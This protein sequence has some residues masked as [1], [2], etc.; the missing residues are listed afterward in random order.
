MRQPD[1]R[2]CRFCSAQG[3]LLP[4][5]A[6]RWRLR[7]T[8]LDLS[9]GVLMGVLNVTPDSFSD[10]GLHLDPEEAVEHGLAMVHQGA[11]IIDVGGESTRPGSEPVHER[12]ELDRVLPVVE[13]L[14]GEGVTVSIDTSKPV[15][16]ESAF[17]RGAEILND[18][19]AC[20]QPGMAELVAEV[21]CG[22]VLMHMMGTP[23]AMHLD[24][25]YD[26][27]IAEVEEFLVQRMELVTAAGVD[28]S[29]IVIDPGIGFGKTA[30]HNLSLINALE[31][32][33]RHAP[34]VL[35]A[36][37]KKFLG[38]ITGASSP[39]DRDLASAVIT[40]VGFLNGAR[41]FRVH[42]VA[43]SKQAL[44]LAAAIVAA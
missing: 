9:R 44:A 37:R 1:P 43:G 31:T 36:S 8:E 30:D 40:T 4:V 13:G 29:S 19:T 6:R 12:V 22:V 35:G 28:P 38:T 39:V 42:D 33:A 18:V 16:A 15:V 5:S 17:S 3:D 11:E 26:D 7:T 32:L 23:E 21:G 10:G 27:V 2:R 25:T 14:S 20:R 41:V 24:P 34:V